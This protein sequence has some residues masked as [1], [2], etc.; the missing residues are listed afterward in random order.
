M[1]I[2]VYDTETTGIPDW[3][4]PSESP[5]Q[6]HLV[7]IAA[8]LI[9]TTTLAVR[10][11]FSAI[12]RP[13]GWSWDENDEAFKAH[14]I[15][16]E[17]ALAEGIPEADALAQYLAMWK[18]ADL[19]VGHNESFDARLLR[20][21]I[22]R[23]GHGAHPPLDSQ[24]ARDELADRFK[25]APAYCTMN[26]SKAVMKIP[27]TPAMIR[28]GKGKWFKPP[29]LNEAHRHFFGRPHDNAH[30]ALS[31]AEAC[32]RIY[33]ALTQPSVPI[34]YCLLPA[35]PV[36]DGVHTAAEQ[37]FA[38]GQTVTEAGTITDEAYDGIQSGADRTTSGAIG[39]P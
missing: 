17:Q 36:S 13:D 34:P 24:E 5:Q 23:Y 10:D 3:K 12:I 31:D 25:P 27:A 28:S 21:A 14:G 38:Q 15:T 18:Q 19:R 32:A 26:T 9:D 29:N 16:M 4:E 11:F 22:K 20:I 7:E 37:A 30:R 1:L 39:Q 2:L 35:E 8:I 6:P 33:L